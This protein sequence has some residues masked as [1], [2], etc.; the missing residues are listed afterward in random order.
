[1]SYGIE[2]NEILDKCNLSDIERKKF[3]DFMDGKVIKIEEAYPDKVDLIKAK[4][5]DPLLDQASKK[6][7]QAGQWRNIIALYHKYYHY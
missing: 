2:L 5:V 7:Y 6:I 4:E 3:E 1:M